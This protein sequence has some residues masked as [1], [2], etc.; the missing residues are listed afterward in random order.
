MNAEVMKHIKEALIGIAYSRCL[1][2]GSQARGDADSD[3][4]YDLLIITTN[5]LSQEEKFTI[6]DRI[7]DFIAPHLIP[8][9][10][11]IQ[12]EEDVARNRKFAGSLIRNA[13]AEGI[14]I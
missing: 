13:L 8:V 6:T 3:S 11:I 7:R 5:T 10:I 14:G 4:D 9:D 1:L 12:S 2:F